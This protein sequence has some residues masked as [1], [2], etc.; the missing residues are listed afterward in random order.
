MDGIKVI[1]AILGIMCLTLA[2]DVADL[3][4]RLI[5]PGEKPQQPPQG[6]FRPQSPSEQFEAE[7]Q[8]HRLEQERI[9]QEQQRFQEEQRIRQ[10]EL[11]RQQAQKQYFPQP[12]EQKSPGAGGE[13]YIDPLNFQLPHTPNRI[14]QR[15]HQASESDAITSFAWRLF[16]GIKPPNRHTNIIVSPLLTQLSLSLLEGG[17]EG[18]SREQ[19]QAAVQS[20]PDLLAHVV[21]T[22]K[23]T[24]ATTSLEYSAALFVSNYLK[25][26]GSFAQR[27]KQAG[28][29]VVPVDFPNQSAAIKQINGWIGQA[30]RNYIPNFLDSSTQTQGIDLLLA[31]AVFFKSVWKYPFNETF[32][33]DFNYKDG[34]RGQVNYMRVAKHMRTGSVQQ[35]I[36]GPSGGLRWVEIPYA[37]GEFSM[38]LIVPQN[39]NT[40]EE[41][42]RVMTPSHLASII[43]E[44]EF[45]MTHIVKLQ[46]PKFHLK[47]RVALA[48]S[49]LEMGISN[50]FTSQSN[51]P[52][53]ALN[54]PVARVT[55]CIQ[56][57][58]LNVDELGTVATAVNSFSVITLSISV[59]DPEIT[60]TVD[61]PF[62]ALIVDK[63]QKVP[64]FISKIYNP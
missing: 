9:Q 48:K 18:Y 27:A 36:S 41:L 13:N 17:A 33:G 25:I 59:P 57:A 32:K 19:I 37:G 47:S 24:H 35:G 54:A 53:I 28:S 16:K 63:R 62:L 60:F 1:L 23:N 64:L 5:F 42:I 26:N 56:H 8:R 50:I 49:L 14:T 52:Y 4:D 46:M 10:E 21:R 15:P 43:D 7:Q 12:A 3:D 22:L 31:N 34:R 2:H 30:T 55:D 6:A 39:Q 11:H 38:I 29:D 40:L 20:S 51:L 58:V 45:A 44:L 61:E